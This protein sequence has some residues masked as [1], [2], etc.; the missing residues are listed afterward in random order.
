MF[1]AQ[2]FLLRHG[3]LERFYRSAFAPKYRDDSPGDSTRNFC[4]S[5]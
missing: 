4:V 1:P 3:V 5:H 2:Y